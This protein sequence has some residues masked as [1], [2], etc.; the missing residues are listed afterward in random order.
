MRL[1]PITL[2]LGRVPGTKNEDTVEMGKGPSITLSAVTDRKLTSMLCEL[3]D[4][5]SIPYQVSV[6]PSSTG[7]NAVGVQLARDGIPVVDVGLPLASMHTYNEIIS[8]DDA[9]ALSDLVSAFVCDANIAKCFKR[10]EL[11]L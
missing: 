11:D 1:I 10:G 2:N 5:H 3:A 7:T 4:K 6:A 8:L 9:K